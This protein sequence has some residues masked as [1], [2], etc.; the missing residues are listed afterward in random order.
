MLVLTRKAT[1]A[2]KIEGPSTVTVLKANGNVRIGI[3]AP[4]S[5]S[6]VR[7]ELLERCPNCGHQISN[8]EEA[9][10]RCANCL[11]LWTPARPL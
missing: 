2:I 5:V 8:R 9:K 7:A 10:R 3:E 4:E 1:E 6:I 11:W